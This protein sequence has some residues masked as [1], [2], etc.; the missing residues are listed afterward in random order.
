MSCCPLRLGGAAA[1]VQVSLSA[2]MLLAAMQYSLMIFNF[3]PHLSWHVVIFALV[4]HSGSSS[5]YPFTSSS[6]LSDR[7]TLPDGLA[8]EVVGGSHEWGAILLMMPFSKFCITLRSSSHLLSDSFQ[9]CTFLPFAASAARP[10]AGQLTDFEQAS[11]MPTSLASGRLTR[12][13]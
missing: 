11:V 4:G 9:K 8:M 3:Y 12:C 6:C 10:G 13:T 7:Q 5:R 2:H 1:L